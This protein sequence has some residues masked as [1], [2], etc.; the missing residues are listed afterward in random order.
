MF[1]SSSASPAESGPSLTSLLSVIIVIIVASGASL[2]IAVS[3]AVR[4]FGGYLLGYTSAGFIDHGQEPHSPP[5]GGYYPFLYSPRRGHPRSL[6]PGWVLVMMLA[7]TALAASE[8]AVIVIVLA[9]FLAGV[10]IWSISRR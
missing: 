2:V 7:M 10:H 9:L 8:L 5:R 1:A 4:V 6:A 3:N